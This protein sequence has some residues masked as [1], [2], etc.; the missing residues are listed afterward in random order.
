MFCLE[1]L[2]VELAHLFWPTR[3]AV[4]QGTKLLFLAPARLSVDLEGAD[5]GRDPAALHVTK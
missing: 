2:A 5:F 1:H 4:L 3:A